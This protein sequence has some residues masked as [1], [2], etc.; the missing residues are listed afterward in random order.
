MGGLINRKVAYLDTD[1]QPLVLGFH[2]VGDAHTCTNPLYGRG[3]SLAM[4]QAD[5]LADAF[6]DAPGHDVD[7]LVARAIAYEAAS[8]REVRPWY[9]AAVTQDRLNRQAAAD[10][11]LERDG[12]PSAPPAEAPGHEDDGDRTTREFVQSIMRDGLLPA[13]RTDAT[14]FRAFV[15]SFNLLDPPDLITS[16]PDVI[17]RVL[18]AYQS[19][20]E[21]PPEEPLGPDRPGLLTALDP[22]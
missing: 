6:A 11:A 9:R 8:D 2:A 22:A 14:V 18:A 13:V 20:D 21:R 15:R 16:D 5:L 3:C 4:V 19:R 1:G 10:R 12:E 17:S 7:A